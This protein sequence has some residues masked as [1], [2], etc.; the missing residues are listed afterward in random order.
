MFF[1]SY[2]FFAGGHSSFFFFLFVYEELS[3]PSGY[4]IGCFNSLQD[5]RSV[6]LFFEKIVSPAFLQAVSRFY[7]HFALMAYKPSR[8]ILYLSYPCW[9]TVVVLF[10][11]S[12]GRVLVERW[13]WVSPNFSAL[14]AVPSAIYGSSGDKSGKD[15]PMSQTRRA[16]PIVEVYHNSITNPMFLL[17]TVSLL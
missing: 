15:K 9:K 7:F 4:L 1:R 16:V 3:I 6:G 12:L 10:N 11:L 8:V 5:R 13:C 2:F 17:L 14:W